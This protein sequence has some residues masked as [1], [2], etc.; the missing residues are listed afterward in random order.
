MSRMKDHYWDELD[1]FPPT[2]A[3]LAKALR[4]ERKR[5]REQEAERT[6]QVWERRKARWNRWKQEHPAEAKALADQKA[7]ERRAQ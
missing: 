1:P 4:A 3:E 5:R 7:R 2:E 6:R